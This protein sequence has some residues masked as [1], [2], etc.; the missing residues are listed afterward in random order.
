MLT[1]FLQLEEALWE[2]VAPGSGTYSPESL[3]HGLGREEGG[4]EV[5]EAYMV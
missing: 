5:E 2:A 1:T 3:S 4:P